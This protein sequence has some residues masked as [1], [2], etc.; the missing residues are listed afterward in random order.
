MS[1]CKA[2]WSSTLAL[3]LLMLQPFPQWQIKSMPSLKSFIKNQDVSQA[4]VRQTF[5]RVELTFSFL[6]YITIFIKM[7]RMEFA[8][9]EV[10]HCVMCD[11]QAVV[12]GREC[13]GAGELESLWKAMCSAAAR[14]LTVQ[15]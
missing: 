11:V 3:D 9:A 1:L 5:L 7:Q 15:P 10:C 14:M 2:V 8:P 12:G 13:Y 6:G 4:A